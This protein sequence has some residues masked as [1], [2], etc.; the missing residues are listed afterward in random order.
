V[1]KPATPS[2][3]IAWPAALTLGFALLSIPAYAQG[4]AQCRDNTVATSPATQR[5]YRHAIILMS[6]AAATFFLTTLAIMKR[7][8]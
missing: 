6:T 8:R 3:H 4:C 5:A 7:N 1:E 2:R